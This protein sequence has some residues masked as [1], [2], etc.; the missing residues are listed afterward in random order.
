MYLG[1]PLALALSAVDADPG[2]LLHQL[3]VVLLGVGRLGRGGRRGRAA[4]PL[5][6]V[7]LLLLPGVLEVR[8]A[9]RDRVR[10]SCDEQE[11]RQG[12]RWWG[13]GAAHAGEA[14]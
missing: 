8:P 10:V 2:L 13:T 9:E 11:G 3:Q 4:L 1:E 6:V 14:R 5:D 12:A 7:F